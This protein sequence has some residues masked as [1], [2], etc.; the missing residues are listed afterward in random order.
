MRVTQGEQAHPDRGSALSCPNTPEARYL[1]P[2]RESLVK[3]AS[4]QS[5]EFLGNA[6]TSFL[7]NDVIVVF[8][9]RK[10]SYMLLFAG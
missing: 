6:D 10:Y 7:R 8:V 9:V 3:T 4:R 2:F 5:S 1:H